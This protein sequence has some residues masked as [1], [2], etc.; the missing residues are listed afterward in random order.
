M[1]F[2]STFPLQG[3]TRWEISVILRHIFQSTFPLQGTTH[4]DIRDCRNGIFQST[5][6]LQG[7]TESHRDKWDPVCI[8]IHVP[9]AGNDKS[10]K[11]K[12]T[13]RRYFNPRSHCRERRTGKQRFIRC[14]T[15]FNPRSHCRERL[16]VFS[17]LRHV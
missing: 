17:H 6:P 8:S 9:I 13:R 2:Q 10:K 11:R 7:T 1:S 15:N 5:F 4:F 16:C 3:T 12:R 14:I